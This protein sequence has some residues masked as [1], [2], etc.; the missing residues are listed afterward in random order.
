MAERTYFRSLLRAA[1]PPGPYRG[2]W[3]WRA[4][5]PTGRILD[6][7]TQ[8]MLE[9]VYLRFPSHCPADG[10]PLH[11]RAR[12]I[13][14][15]PYEDADAYRRRLVQ[16]LDV[17]RMAGL[18]A[19]ILYAIQGYLAPTYPRV[20]LVTRQGLWV[21]L[22][23]GGSLLPIDEALTLPGDIP[24]TGG[25]P[26]RYVPPLDAATHA[27][28]W[29][30]RNDPALWNWD[31]L[32]HPANATRWWDFWLV[33]YPGA[34]DLQGNF[35]S[36]LFYDEP[37]T[38]GFSEPQGTFDTLRTLVDQFRSAVSFC[39]AV[40]FPPDAGDFDPTEAPGAAGFPDGWWGYE[41]RVSAGQWVP[42]RRRDCRFMLF[43]E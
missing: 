14:R 42:A 5:E 10:L 43:D 26:Y 30:Q 23:E 31:S 29:F 15:G 37:T 27:P 24:P 16:W 7:T 28:L 39:R 19:G 33:I 3:A 35:D 32:S 8:A 21:T 13:P 36:G 6:V 11:G 4:L 1:L 41:A 40:V 38:W 25:S 12:R 20:R 18:Y 22:E 9:A 17:W 2:P 34:Y